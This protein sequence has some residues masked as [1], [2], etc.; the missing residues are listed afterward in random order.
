MPEKI[1][2]FPMDVTYRIV[3]NKAII[4][5]FG[6][7]TTGTQICIIDDTFQPYFIVVPKDVSKVKEK[8]E[9][10]KVEEEERISEVTKTEIIKK[11]ERAN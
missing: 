10:I 7:T 2:F 11:I 6:K 3:D 1:Q 9:K 8:L 4:H 5:L